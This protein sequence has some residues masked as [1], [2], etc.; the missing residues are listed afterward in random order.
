MNY[1]LEKQTKILT[2]DQPSTG[3]DFQGISHAY[4]YSSFFL[5]IKTKV[6]PIKWGLSSLCLELRWLQHTECE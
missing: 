2:D 3:L 5:S 6:R 4:S 1:L